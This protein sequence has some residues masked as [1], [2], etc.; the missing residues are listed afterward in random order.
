[1]DLD[2]YKIKI[3]QSLQSICSSLSDC[4]GLQESMIYSLLAGGKR[5]RP[6]LVLEFSRICGGDFDLTLPVALSVELLHTYS[7]IHDDLPCMDDDDLRRGRPTNHKVFG[8]DIAVLA[9]DALQAAAFS[10][11]ADCQLPAEKTVSCCKSL[12][13]AAGVFGMCGG[14][15]LDIKIPEAE[16]DAEHLDSIN[17]MKTGALLSCACELG[18]ICGGG[19][20]EQLKSATLFGR[21]IGLAF[22]IMDD[23][24][25]VTSSEDQLGKTIGSDASINKHTY[26]SVLG[27]KA[28]KE[29]VS[30]L[31]EEAKNAVIP[32]F[33][34]CASLLKFADDM[35]MRTF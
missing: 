35:S 30:S 1:M 13:K 17:S 31:T 19:T 15:Y 34:D 9:G 24:L 25:D 12:A 28:C 26:F 10:L 27:I 3:D 14:Q 11:I 7:L 4:C 22:Q 2:S 20:E 18:V 21:K 33:S 16:R 32:Y 5:I 6:A 29:A 8:E 23:V